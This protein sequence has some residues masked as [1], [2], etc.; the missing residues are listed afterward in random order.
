MKTFQTQPLCTT[1][2]LNSAKPK[3]H[4]LLEPPTTGVGCAGFF[5]SMS[6]TPPGKKMTFPATSGKVIVS[7]VT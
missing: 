3:H 4:I 2:P 1:V 6:A 7:L 5:Y